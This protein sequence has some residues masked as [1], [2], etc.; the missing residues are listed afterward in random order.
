MNKNVFCIGPF[1]FDKTKTPIC[2]PSDQCAALHPVFPEYAPRGRD[3][4]GLPEW[5]FIPELRMADAFIVITLSLN[6]EY[7]LDTLAA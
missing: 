1:R 4:A 6:S 2:V 5:R 7:L 3:E